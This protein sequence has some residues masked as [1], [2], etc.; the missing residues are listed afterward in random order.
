MP[1][2]FHNWL[3]NEKREIKI[4]RLND[5]Q[6]SIL[7]SNGNLRLRSKIGETRE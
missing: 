1:L 4:Q 6:L 5:L 3:F 2:E 7:S